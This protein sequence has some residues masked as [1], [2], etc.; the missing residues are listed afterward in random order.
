MKASYQTADANH[1]SIITVEELATHLSGG[2]RSTSTSNAGATVASAAGSPDVSQ[3]KSY[4]AVS[5]QDRLPSGLPS[6]FKEKDRDG[7]GQISMSEYSSAWDDET[8]Q[9]FGKYDL[10]GDG[11]ITPAECLKSSGSR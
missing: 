11:V 8:A 2:S 4:R 3:R 5:A 9:Q 6:W 1:D 10:N 7:D